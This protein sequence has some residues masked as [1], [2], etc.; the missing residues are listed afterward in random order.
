MIRID[1]LSLE[2]GLPKASVEDTG[3]EPDSIESKLRNSADPVE[4]IWEEFDRTLDESKLRIG[5][6]Y[7][8]AIIKA[9]EGYSIVYLSGAV[10]NPTLWKRG[11]VKG[12]LLKTSFPDVY[13][14]E[15]KSAG[16][17]K[18]DGEIKAQREGSVIA[19]QFPYHNSTLRLRKVEKSD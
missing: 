18:V 16:G 15:W 9:P 7:R 12:T 4:G 14:I 6:R 8:L 5:G 1:D 13:D 10:K 2:Y 11:M 17:G 19:I 3:L